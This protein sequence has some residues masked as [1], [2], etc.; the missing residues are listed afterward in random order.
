MNRTRRTPSRPFA[1]SP[2]TLIPSLQIRFRFGVLIRVEITWAITSAS[3]IDSAHRSLVAHSD[4]SALLK[5]CLDWSL[6]CSSQSLFLVSHI[7][8]LAFI[9]EY[10]H[11]AHQKTSKL[12]RSHFARLLRGPRI[13]L[14]GVYAFIFERGMPC[15]AALQLPAD[16]VG[17][18]S[19]PASLFRSC[20]GEKNTDEKNTN[21][22]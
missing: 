6:P 14:G 1:I 3:L 7:S 9:P 8:S 21:K 10:R 22:L 19:L 20:L 17:Q 5:F 15:D 12:L 2:I 18:R 11:M 13:H 16:A 4:D